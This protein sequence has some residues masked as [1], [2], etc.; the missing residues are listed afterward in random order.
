[1]GITLPDWLRTVLGVDAVAVSDAQANVYL[2]MAMQRINAAAPL[3]GIG[4]F[5]TVA[6][7][8]KY[9][10]LAAGNYTIQ[11]A[12][13]CDPSL[14]LYGD[15]GLAYNAWMVQFNAAFGQPIDDIGTRTALDPATVYIVL[16]KQQQ[17]ERWIGTNFAVV[18]NAADVYLSGPPRDV[19]AVYFSF[20]GPR[21][22]IPGDV[23]TMYFDAFWWAVQSAA[24]G[25]FAVGGGAVT[26]VVDSQEGT[27]ISL[28]TG[29][30]SSKRAADAERAFL[31]ALSVPPVEQWLFG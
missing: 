7:T 26:Q 1:M 9:S 17:V 14:W 21:F 6:G 11:Q 2:R 28:N 29:A 27:S 30:A 31:R 18:N 15:S 8:Q 20:T 22:A 25:A 24:L 16:E 4:T 3:V 23:T 19:R 12:W 5:N 10:P 13:W